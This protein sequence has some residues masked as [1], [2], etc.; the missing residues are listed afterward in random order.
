MDNG[1]LSRRFLL[2]RGPLVAAGAAAWLSSDS[3]GL[4]AFARGIAGPFANDDFPIPA[5]KKFTKE[6]IDSLTARGTPLTATSARDELKY[7]GMPVGGVGCGLVYLSAD[8]R[9]WAWD[10]SNLPPSRPWADSSGPMYASPVT[11]SGDP[12]S[13]RFAFRIEEEGQ[14]PRSLSASGFRDVVFTGQYPVGTVRFTDKST[15]LAVELTAFSPFCPLDVED[16][17]LPCVIM[18]YRV[19]NTGKSAATFALVGTM[20]NHVC[21]ATAPTETPD[22]SPSAVIRENKVVKDATGTTLSIVAESRAVA[23][24][25]VAKPDARKDLLIDDFESGTYNGWAATG[26]AFGDRPRKLSDIAKYQGDLRAQGQYTVNTHESRHGENVEDADKHIGTLTSREFKVERKFVSLRVGGGNHPGQTCVNLLVDGAPVRT[27]TGEDNNAMRMVNWDVSEFEGKQACIQIVDAWKGG[28]GQIGV[29]DIV[30]TDTPRAALYEMES[31]PDFGTMALT[32]LNAG[33]TAAASATTGKTNPPAGEIRVPLTLEP[34]ASAELSFAAIWYFPNLNRGSLGFIADIHKLRRHYAARF[35]DAPAISAFLAANH[36][37][38]TARTLQWRDTWYDSTL[39]YW[40][41]DRTFATV[42]TA[43]TTTCFL[44]DNGRFYGWEGT[45]CCAGTCTHV[46]QYAQALAR[47]FPSLERSLRQNIDFGQEFNDKTGVI[48]YR[49]EAARHLAIDGQ[50]GTIVRAYREHTMTPDGSMLKAIYPRVK[51]AMQMVIARDKEAD[52]ILDGEQYNTLDTSWYGKIAWISS[53]YLAALRASAAMAADMG[54]AEF[55]ETCTEIADRGRENFAKTL[56]NGEYFIH[57]PDS[58]HPETNSTGN[59]CHSDQLLGQT[60]AWQN[61]LGRIVPKK[62]TVAALRSIYKYNFALDVGTYRTANEKTIKGGRWYAM[63]GEGGLIVCT[64][65]KGGSE[66]ASGKG[67]DAW[68]AI[69]FNECWTGFEHHI[70]SHMIA[71]DMITEGLAITKMLHE[72][73]HPAKRNPYNEVEC[74]SHYARAMSSYGSFVSACGFTHHG[75]KGQLG[76]APRVFPT[77]RQ[78]GDRSFRSPFITC[79]GWGTYEQHQA[80]GTFTITLRHGKLRLTS[81]SLPLLKAGGNA[82]VSA[83]LAVGNAEAK[84]AGKVETRREP[85]AASGFGTCT[86][87]PPGGELTL[88]AGQTLAVTLS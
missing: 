35:K 59:G 2:T 10:V 87:T 45:H 79:E 37:R 53:L 4:P 46:W 5:D 17:S 56:F 85:E 19:T 57:I 51:K 29:D 86:L 61:G 14:T 88:T 50:C 36:E 3:L 49:G 26:T 30:Q 84:P 55:A 44:F 11:P 54:D 60:Y 1:E 72:R 43:A 77:P 25:A 76:F 18:R 31:A 64:W 62:Q 23:Q 71:E 27:A 20:T 21:L 52:G 70:A 7:V 34:G 12:T 22:G 16:S 67:G 83:S 39:P 58:A 6:W 38:L 32:L 40:F 82:T 13:D 24:T 65:P 66:A 47:V 68:A 33:P 15:P 63:P 75:P 41:L 80:K 42:S 78:P 9:L 28:W 8:G 69:Y 74:S 81:L 48:H 73:H